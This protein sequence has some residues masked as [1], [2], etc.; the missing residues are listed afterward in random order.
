MSAFQIGCSVFGAIFVAELPDKTAL[1]SLVLATRHRPAPVFLGASLALALQSVVAV[2]AGH[3]LSLLSAEVVHL[4]A[5]TLFLGCAVVMWRRREEAPEAAL[6]AAPGITR[7]AAFFPALA[8]V[9][10]V[11]FVAEWGDLTQFGTAAFAA[12]YR[13]PVA[14]FLGATLALCAVTGIAVF[15]GNRTGA[16]LDADRVQKLAALVFG[17]IGA[18]LVTGLL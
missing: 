10:G 4:V 13:A 6:E 8:K 12:H 16:A 17:A 18:A 2:G 14:V 7:G 5:G 11:V 1:A 3:L 15:A 9:F